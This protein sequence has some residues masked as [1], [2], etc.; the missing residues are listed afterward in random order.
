MVSRRKRR[1][2]FEKLAIP[3]TDALFGAAFRMTRSQQGAEDLVQETMLRAY[4][5]WDTFQQDSN[6]KAWLFRILTNTFIN[7]YQKN[8]RSREVLDAAHNEQRATD[9]ILVHERALDL[10]NPEELLLSQTLSD[11]VVRA[12]ESLPAD[13]RVAVVLCDVEGF[14]YKEI[15]EILECPVGTVMSRLHRGRRLLQ[16]ALYDFAVEQG[17]IKPKPPAETPEAEAP[18][19][20][21]AG[22]IDLSEYR[23]K[24][25]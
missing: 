11:D 25:G 9:G 10:R 15:A 21:D 2:E 16:A 13:F 5:F 3:H 7:S 18:E 19:G 8:K 17:V 4:R 6:C 14:S 23:K 12:L 1:S 24:K 20:S 22:T